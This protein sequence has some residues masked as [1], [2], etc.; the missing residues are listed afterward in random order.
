MFIASSPE[1]HSM[2]RCF[3][4][5]D[6]LPHMKPFCYDLCIDCFRFIFQVDDARQLTSFQFDHGCAFSVDHLTTGRR[7][8]ITMGI[9]GGISQT[10]RKLINLLGGHLPQRR[11]GVDQG[12]VVDHEVWR[13]VA[14]QQRP[15]PGA[16]LPILGH[17]DPREVMRRRVL[18]SQATNDGGVAPAAERPYSITEKREACRDYDPER[19]PL[20][21][22]THVH[23][24]YSFDAASQNTCNTPNDA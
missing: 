7:D 8:G 21:G 10:S 19:R 1:S 11:V 4:H 2:L 12:G 3:D 20:F 24:A 13:T 5:S 6:N 15:N 17:V 9:M 16:D 18:F 14:R 23:T 22:D